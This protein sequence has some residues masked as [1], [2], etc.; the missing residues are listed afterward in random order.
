MAMNMAMAMAATT[1]RRVTRQHRTTRRRVRLAIRS[2]CAIIVA[3][4]GYNSVAYSLATVVT[5]SDVAL[6]YR[7]AP[8][9]GQVLA[10]R[11]MA[12]AGTGVTG[13]DRNLAN[14]FARR[15]LH[16]EAM[17]VNAAVALAINAAVRG[18]KAG[19][20]RAFA[21]SQMLSRRNLPTQFWAIEDAVERGDVVGAL[22]HYD[23]AL[24]TSP[25]TGEILFPI[26]TS[27][28]ADPAIGA[29]LVT[30]LAS[31]PIWGEAFISYLATNGS[32]PTAT[33]VFLR[34]LRHAGVDVPET[35]RVAVIN[36]L[37]AGGYANAAWA[38]YAL[39][40]PGYNRARS[41]DP[42]FAASLNL[43]S[44]LDW[45]TVE[46]PGISTSIQS[47]RAGGIVEFSAP[48]SIAG[49]LLRQL[50]L[51]PPGSYRLAGH[52]SGIDQP[53]GE[54]PY[55]LLTCHDGREL[56]RV[57]MPQSD[58]SAGNFAGRVDVPAGCGIQ[59]LQLIARPVTAASGL[60]GQIDRVQLEPAQ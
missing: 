18:D 52:A 36:A 10:A 3:I 23:I 25:K 32:D 44:Q 2:V 24:R 30:I 27:A 49:P 15:A 26:L 17:A 37:A 40:R 59:M 42:R 55:W 43:P 48:A 6:A 46:T 33:A 21:Y 39:G 11:A 20:R 57:E 50:Q 56:G 7:L 45:V 13:A 38:Y 22:R 28:S 35:A 58:R 14:G 4:L 51:L 34:R 5:R 12:L 16:D 47:G 29:G 8:G 53:D 9:S 1:R 41:R 31:R 19:A 60:T 54:R